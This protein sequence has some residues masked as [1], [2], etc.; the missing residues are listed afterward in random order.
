MKGIEEVIQIIQKKRHTLPLCQ[1]TLGFDGFIDSIVKII[2]DKNDQNEPLFFPN[3]QDF[4]H[5]VLHKSASSFSLEIAEQSVKLGGNM[6]I[7]AHAL[8]SLGV[9][10]NC[11]GALGYPHIHPIFQDIVPNGHLFSFAEPGQ[12]TAFEFNDGKMMMAQMGHLN[13]MGWE[14]IKAKIGLD[15]LIRLFSASKLWAM[16]NWSEIDASSNIWRGLLADVIPHCRS[17][18]NVPIAFFDLSDC[19]KRSDESILDM[20]GLLQ[21]FSGCAQVILSLNNNEARRILA[22][23]SPVSPQDFAEIGAELYP[24]LKLP[25]LVLHTTQQAF[26]FTPDGL[27]SCSSFWTPTPKLSTGAGDHFSAG[28]AAAQLMHLDWESALTFANAVAGCYVRNGI[29]PTI[30]GV[31][32]FLNSSYADQ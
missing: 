16:L 15:T 1:A 21:L 28:I 6:P 23:F 22:C 5:Y 17:S 11:V 14:A 25:N 10:A 7:T 12:A 29:S 27:F 8:A 31:I 18:E 9:R 2:K 30:D 26:A 3:I 13:Q 19:S 32:Q 20:V 4:G 24:H